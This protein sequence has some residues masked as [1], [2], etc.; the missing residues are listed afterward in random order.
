VP[1]P[2]LVNVQLGQAVD[3]LHGFKADHYGL[4]EKAPRV[5]EPYASDKMEGE[6][7]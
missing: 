6:R 1:R 4:I 7:S 3:D 5:F 2:G